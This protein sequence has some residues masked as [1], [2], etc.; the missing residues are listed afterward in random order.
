M[1][2]TFLYLL[3]KLDGLVSLAGRIEWPFFALFLIAVAFWIV[4]WI[5]QTWNTTADSRGVT[6]SESEVEKIETSCK[7]LRKSAVKLIRISLYFWLPLMLIKT[8]IPT[9]KEMA[10]IYVVPKI[11]NSKHV[12]EIPKELLRLST[13]WLEGLSPNEIGKKIVKEATKE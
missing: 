7:S 4:C 12:Q 11:V 2:H 6:P 1:S 9:T 13:E 5:V 10:V 8:M 3:V